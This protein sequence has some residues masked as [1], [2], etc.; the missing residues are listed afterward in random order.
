MNTP[1]FYYV[2]SFHFLAQD[3][4]KEIIHQ[5]WRKEFYNS[6]PIIARQEAFAE[7]DEYLNF[8][9]LNKK[10]EKDEYGNYQIVSPSG[11]PE[12]PEITERE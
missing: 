4:N 7:F 8:L 9:N 2:V 5:N 1:P 10:V 3:K 6:N 11:V 12:R